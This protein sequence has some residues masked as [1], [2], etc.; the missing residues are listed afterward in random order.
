[1]TDYASRRLRHTVLLTLTA[2]LLWGC[3]GTPEQEEPVAPEPEPEAPQEVTIV[4]PFT[5]PPSAFAPVF[6]EAEAWLAQFDWMRAS[7]ALDTL[8]DEQLSATDRFY[9]TYLQAR[10]AF[11]RGDADAAMRMLAQARDEAIGAGAADPALTYRNLSFRHHLLE[12]TGQYLAAAQAADYIATLVPQ[13]QRR[14]WYRKL[15]HHL[16]RLD[17]ATLQAAR[18]ADATSQWQAWLELALISREDGA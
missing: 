4:D 1:M 13:A 11:I 18:S 6:A 14:P 7:V 8:P 5:L 10:I 15:W 3:A 12:M 17:T 9:V 2:T 16:E